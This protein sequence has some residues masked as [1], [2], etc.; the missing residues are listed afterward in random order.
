MHDSALARGRLV[1]SEQGVLAGQ[2]ERV[3]VEVHAT[4]GREQHELVQ[5]VEERCLQWQ[6]TV[7]RRVAV[8]VG[9][10]DSGDWVGAGER[11]RVGWQAG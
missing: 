1:V 6:V 4:A 8:S 9:V 10:W 2:V 7:G 11:D 5:V 3:A